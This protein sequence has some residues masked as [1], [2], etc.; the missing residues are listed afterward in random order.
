VEAQIERLD[1]EF[2]GSESERAAPKFRDARVRSRK[3]GKQLKRL[4]RRWDTLSK[5]HGDLKDALAKL[6]T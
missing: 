5:D 4:Y 2:P 1:A 3:L 6:S